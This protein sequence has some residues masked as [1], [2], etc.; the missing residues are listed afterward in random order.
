MEPKYQES[1]GAFLLSELQNWPA[2]TLQ[3]AKEMEQF[4]GTLALF[5]VSVFSFAL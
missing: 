2:T 5:T 1:K 4:E 3:L